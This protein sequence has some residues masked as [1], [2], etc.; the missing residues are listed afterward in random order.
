MVRTTLSLSREFTDRVTNYIEQPI[1]VSAV[2]KILKGDSA[3]GR[4]KIDRPCY[5]NSAYV[6]KRDALIPKAEAYCDVK[7]RVT[8]HKNRGG[9]WSRLFM[10]VMD[11]MWEL[12]VLTERS[13]KMSVELAW[14]Q[15]R[16]ADLREELS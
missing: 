4:N 6:A 9:D 3:M 10:R 2:R 1:N 8:S 14:I 5:G 15:V 7:L 16:Q 13:E 11:R 12:Q